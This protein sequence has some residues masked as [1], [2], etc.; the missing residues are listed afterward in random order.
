MVV[1]VT[2][3]VVVGA[4]AVVDG[5]VEDAASWV[6]VDGVVPTASSPAA[7]Q[8][9]AITLMAATTATATSC[10][11]RFVRATSRFRIAASLS[12]DALPNGFVGRMP[13]STSRLPVPVS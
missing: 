13:M 7:L 10:L 4:A 2:A 9:A 1:V 12:I 3:V 6:E 8:L 5:T 11:G